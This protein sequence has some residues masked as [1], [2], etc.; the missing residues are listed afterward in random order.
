MCLEP[1]GGNRYFQE[2]KDEKHESSFLKI[3]IVVVWN[4]VNEVEILT[5]M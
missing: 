1:Y 5:R 3:Q 4:Y 2:P